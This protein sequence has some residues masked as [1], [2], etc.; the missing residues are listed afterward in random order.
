MATSGNF[1]AQLFGVPTTILLPPLRLDRNNYF[2]LQSQ[3]LPAIRAHDLEDILLYRLPCPAPRIPEIE[4]ST[5]IVRKPDF[6][7]W[8]RLDQFLISW[9]M[10]SISESMIGHVVNCESSAKI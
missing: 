9:L 2:F 1:L 7:R 10:S 4:G 6:V 3:V 8:M 5:N